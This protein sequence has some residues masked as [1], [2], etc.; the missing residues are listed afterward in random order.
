MWF[1]YALQYLLPEQLLEKRNG[2]A[3]LNLTIYS[4]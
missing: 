2:M 1:T 4:I 3:T